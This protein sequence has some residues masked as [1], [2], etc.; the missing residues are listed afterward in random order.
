M[1]SPCGIVVGPIIGG[2]I[3]AI[4]QKRC[5]EAHL[6]IQ[7]LLNS[8]LIVGL[9]GLAFDALKIASM[10]FDLA[11]SYIP[12]LLIDSVD[13]GK[14]IA[15][16]VGRSIGTGGATGPLIAFDGRRLDGGIIVLFATLKSLVVASVAVCALHSA[17]FP[18]EEVVAEA[19][20]KQNQ[21]FGRRKI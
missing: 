17:S 20:L 5:A 18:R 12:T 14:C 16:A 3:E 13:I 2:I 11:A 6:Q 19:Y 7:T 15:I 8:V 1:A 21:D 10:V 9:Q 4:L